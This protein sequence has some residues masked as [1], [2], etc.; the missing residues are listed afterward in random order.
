MV[1]YESLLFD[2][3]WRVDGSRDCFLFATYYYHDQQYSS[4]GRIRVR[5]L[6]VARYCYGC[7]DSGGNMSSNFLGRTAHIEAE[8]KKPHKLMTNCADCGKHVDTVVDRYDTSNGYRPEERHIGMCDTKVGGCGA[9]AYGKPTIGGAIA[10][11]NE[12]QAERWL[13][14]YATDKAQSDS[15][16]ALANEVGVALDRAIA[17]K[18]R[19]NKPPLDLVPFSLTESAARAFAFGTTKYSKHNWRKGM[20]TSWIVRSLLSHIGKWN[21]GE[22]CDVESGLSH[23]DHVAA[24]TAMLIETMTKHPIV[25]DRFKP[26]G[27]TPPCIAMRGAKT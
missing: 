24:C 4:L 12:V 14:R 20:P 16:E 25:D 2:S 1:K 9:T 13:L 11:W 21:E 17:N 10:S 27:S 18:D 3:A 22:D 5:S 26:D 23:L 6:G 19:T 8:C 15:P 7:V